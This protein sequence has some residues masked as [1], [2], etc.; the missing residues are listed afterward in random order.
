MAYAALNVI[1][2]CYA[3]KAFIGLRNSVV[4]A[5]IHATSLLYKS[6]APPDTPQGPAAAVPA[7]DRLA[8]RP[9]GGLRR[10]LVPAGATAPGRQLAGVGIDRR[11]EPL[12][13]PRRSLSPLRLLI[14]LVVLAGAGYGGYAGVQTR[15]ASTRVVRQTWFAPYVDVT[16]TPTYQF[17]N[18]SAD[19]PARPSWVS[20]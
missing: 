20:W 5:W 1:L 7:A 4:D 10:T 15:L 18:P 2:A 6:E 11:P 16:L 13:Q 8:L 9:R 17:Q 19:R 14:A 12:G 3:A